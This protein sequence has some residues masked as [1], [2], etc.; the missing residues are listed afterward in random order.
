[1]NGIERSVI[2]RSGAVIP[3]SVLALLIA[4]AAGCADYRIGAS[5]LYA[6][7]IHTVYVPMFESDSFR[8]NLGERLTEAV[9]K[10]LDAITATI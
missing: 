8:R 4:A 10:E 3:V 1:M 6:P 9:M 7:D 2:R 5:S